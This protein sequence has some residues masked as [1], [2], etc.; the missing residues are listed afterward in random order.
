MIK[1]SDEGGPARRGNNDLDNRN[2]EIRMYFRDRCIHRTSTIHNA[3]PAPDLL[4]LLS[5]TRQREH[6]RRSLVGVEQE[7]ATVDQDDDLA[8]VGHLSG[9]ASGGSRRPANTMLSL[10]TRSR[11]LKEALIVEAD[12]CGG[13]MGEALTDTNNDEDLS[14]HEAG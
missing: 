4:D 13:T 2:T 1:I 10:D 9:T 8:S 11:Q 7:A 14:V 5:A 3:L 12:I 6:L